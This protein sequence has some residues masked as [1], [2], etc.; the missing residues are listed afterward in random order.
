MS[1]NQQTPAAAT[2]AIAGG[3]IG[4]DLPSILRD[5][6]GQ[7][8]GSFH[9]C[10]LTGDVL[11]LQPPQQLAQAAWQVL[12]LATAHFDTLGLISG[13]AQMQV[14]ENRAV[15]G[16]TPWSEGNQGVEPWPSGLGL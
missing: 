14:I 8:L 4:G 9:W 3:A 11:A 10:G 6:S 1:A 15:G 2:T 5:F 7:L 12:L 13:E 16:F